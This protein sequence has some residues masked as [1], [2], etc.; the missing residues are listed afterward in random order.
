MDNTNRS[1]SRISGQH[2]LVEFYNTPRLDDE[3]HIR[4]AMTAAVKASGATLLKIDLHHFGDGKGITGVALLAESHLSIHTWPEH[5][6]AALDI[7]MCGGNAR[8]QAALD[9]LVDVLKP[10]RVEVK[11]VERGNLRDER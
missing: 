7:F 11:K 6:Y 3:S 9:V 1:S 5:G 4:E 10:G 2:W 8:P